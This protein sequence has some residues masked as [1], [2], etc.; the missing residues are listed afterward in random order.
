MS[1]QILQIHPTLHSYLSLA[2]STYPHLLSDKQKAATSLLS[3]TI[4]TSL[5]KLSLIR[6]RAHASLYSKKPSQSCTMANTLENLSAMLSRV[7]RKRAA[8]NRE[9]DERLA[10][11]NEM[12]NLVDG[13]GRGGGGGFRGVVDD[14]VKVK[15]EQE[16]CLRDLRRLGWTGD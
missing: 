10:E 6:A 7:E 13:D 4:E 1:T 8:E 9:L 5:L 15:K 12:L 2:L 3:T 11:Y 16:E 14:W